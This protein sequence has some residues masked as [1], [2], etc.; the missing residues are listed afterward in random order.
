MAGERAEEAAEAC[1]ERAVRQGAKGPQMRAVRRD[2]WT[3]V[4][5]ETFLATL[6]E[7]A[8][9]S[10]AARAAGMSVRGVYA[11]R[12]KDEGFAREWA[13][14]LDQ[15]YDALDQLLLRMALFG[16]EEIEIVEDGAGEVK[17]RKVKRSVPVA[18][19]L[20]L[21]ARR[22][23]DLERRAEQWARE[24]PDSPAVMQR[25]AQSLQRLRARVAET[26]APGQQADERMAPGRGKRNGGGAG[27]ADAGA[28]GVAKEQGGSGDG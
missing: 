6:A 13:L 15:A 9:A 5:R 1:P 11:L 28:S 14:A 26:D 2:G 19:G 12:R 27:K 22:A 25:L 20:A 23:K 16:V 21:S 7:T 8:N 24:R 10:E 4:R 3:R 17:S 18:L